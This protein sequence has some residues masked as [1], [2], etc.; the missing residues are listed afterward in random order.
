VDREQHADQQAHFAAKT[1]AERLQ[2]SLDESDTDPAD[3][4]D[5]RPGRP[6]VTDQPGEASPTGRVGL[7]DYPSDAS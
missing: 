1:E 6:A 4:A 5:T 7:S 3:P 2:T